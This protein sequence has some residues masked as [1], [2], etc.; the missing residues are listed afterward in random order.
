MK[1]AFHTLG[2]KTNAYETQAIIEQ[3]EAAG[4]EITDFSEAA[5]VYVIN[6]CS[7]TAEAARKSRQMLHRAKGKNPDAI[8]AAC[9]CFAQEAKEELLKDGTVDLCIGNNE[10]SSLLSIL[11][12]FREK[13]EDAVLVDDLTHCRQFEPQVISGAGTHIRAYVKVQ[14]GCDRFCS[15]CIIPFLRGRSRSRNLST[16]IKET[17]TLSQQGIHEIVLTGIDISDFRIEEKTPEASLLLLLSKL[18]EVEGIER[19][20]LGS[21]EEGILSAGFIQTLK[22]FPKLCPH[23]HLSLQSGC[24]AT[25]LR[26]NRKYTTEAFEA[27]VL[28]LRETF[29]DPAITTDVICGF[30]GETEAEFEE[31]LSFV[32]RIGFSQMHVFPYSR[33]KGTRADKMEGQL[34]RAEKAARSRRLIE[35]GR[36]MQTAYMESFLGKEVCVLTEET[37]RFQDRAY[38]VGFTPEYVRALV[39]AQDH[40]INRIVTIVPERIEL[41]QKDPVLLPAEGI[42]PIGSF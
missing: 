32:K 21:L 27:V 8:V 22:T 28:M 30:P 15:Y 29:S 9:G 38:L 37:V 36:A 4:Y 40:R 11:T 24:D 1:A 18:H 25:L 19:I 34:S 14:D 41:F 17:E 2:C 33:R 10:K 42:K 23:F 6:T 3:F 26:M 31:T 35:E 20:R 7:V 16:I 12:S 13:R 39:P 5:D